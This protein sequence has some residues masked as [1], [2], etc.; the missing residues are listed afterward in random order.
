MTKR[1]LAGLHGSV[2]LCCS[3][4]AGAGGAAVEAAVCGAAVREEGEEVWREEEGGEIATCAQDYHKET[5]SLNAPAFG[6]RIKGMIELLGPRRAFFA[7]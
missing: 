3:D 1:A 5:L 7:G 4:G 6:R 2:V